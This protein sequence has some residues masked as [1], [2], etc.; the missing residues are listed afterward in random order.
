MINIRKGEKDD[1]PF[2]LELIKELA[3]YEKC[4]HKVNVQISDLE[5][6][7][8]GHNP[9]FYFLVAEKD[10]QIIGMALY[11]IHYSTWDGKCL[12]LE[13][14]IVQKKFRRK[15]VGKLLF[16]KIIDIAKKKK[17]N[18]VMWQVL[19][20]NKTAINFYKKYNAEISDNWLN[21]RLTKNQ[22]IN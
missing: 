4:L 15:G 21:G 13:D 3:D 18:R 1:L 7:G 2:V 20:W 9:L 22:I 12:F 10:T 11:Y 16:N 5:K 19:N 6:D 14:F 8:F 17:F